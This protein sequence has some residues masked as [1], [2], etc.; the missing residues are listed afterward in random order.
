MADQT[1]DSKTEYFLSTLAPLALSGV[2][3]GVAAIVGSGLEAAVAKIL[4]ALP[5]A[6]RLVIVDEDADSAQACKGFVAKDLRLGVI[7]ESPAQFVEDMVEQRF[8]CLLLMP[9]CEGDEQ[10]LLTL[11]WQAGFMAVHPDLET[12]T[13]EEDMLLWSSEAG[14]AIRM[15]PPRPKRR[16][17]RRRTSAAREAA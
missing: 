2:G 5:P 17:G 1:M 8:D 15:L 10:A 11:L 3:E 16:G 6:A 14:A 9:G 12:P 7:N 13:V 4:P